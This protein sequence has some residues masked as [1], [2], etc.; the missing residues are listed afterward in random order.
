MMNIKMI[1]R[2]LTGALL[3]LMVCFMPV[4]GFSTNQEQIAPD[5]TVQNLLDDAQQVSLEQYKG[6]VVYLDFW[7]SWCSPCLK[8]FPFMDELQAEYGDDGFVVIAVNLDENSK[9]AREFMENTQVNFFVGRDEQG[10]LATSYGVKT[11]P[12][13]YLIG[14]DGLIKEIHRGFR[15]SDKEKIR[16]LVSSLL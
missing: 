10:V 9:D 16:L 5:F 13:S 12:S 11:M 2:K 6:K 3:L 1:N 7:A 14:R 8:S 15:S 4:A